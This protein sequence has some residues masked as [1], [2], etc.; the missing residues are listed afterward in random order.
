MLNYKFKANSL[1][2]ISI[3]ITIIGVLMMSTFKGFDLLH[4]VKLDSLIVDTRI[5]HATIS[6]IDIENLNTDSEEEV[7]QEIYSNNIITKKS[8]KLNAGIKICLI[9]NGKTWEIVYKNSNN[10]SKIIEK[11][12]KYLKNQIPEL[13]IKEIENK[14]YEIKYKI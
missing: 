6:D 7:W 14:Y 1:L 4:K 10:V 13:E 3:V 9:K 11:D 8:R 5:I 2:E 12:A